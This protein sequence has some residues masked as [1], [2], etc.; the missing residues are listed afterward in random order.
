MT[1]RQIKFIGFCRIQVEQQTINDVITITNALKLQ[2]V[3]QKMGK[4]HLRENNQQQDPILD[5]T[6]HNPL[7]VK[8]NLVL[9]SAEKTH[10]LVNHYEVKHK[11]EKHLQGYNHKNVLNEPVTVSQVPEG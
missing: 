2:L 4:H 1:K 8:P 10:L 7:S 9:N 6:V 11:R 3:S 5:H